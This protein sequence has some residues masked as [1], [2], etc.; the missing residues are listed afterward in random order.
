MELTI[1]PSPSGK[2]LLSRYTADSY[3]SFRI[4]FEPDKD[5]GPLRFLAQ[6]AAER[7]AAVV[8]V[9]ASDKD[10][11]ALR[12]YWLMA[13]A[14]GGVKRHRVSSDSYMVD[15]FHPVLKARDRKFVSRDMTVDESLIEHVLAGGGYMGG[16]I[17]S[18]TES[19]DEVKSLRLEIDMVLFAD[20][21]IAGPDSEGFAAEL[22]CRKPAAEFVARQIRSAEKEDREVT[23]I[24][25]ALADIPHRRPAGHGQGD[26]ML[27]WVRYYVRDYLRAIPRQI[28]WV[29]IREAKLRHLE[30][31][32]AL[33]KFYREEG[34]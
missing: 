20:G 23:A 26:P 14:H 7:E 8:M 13:T 6:A 4:I 32:P 15:V 17:G 25:S 24:L 2:I 10:V 28:G 9:N 16:Q 33:P 11:T 12:Y 5:P 30:S 18:K 21:E 27:H 22:Q 3:P 29:N 31:R 19:F 1:A 34:G